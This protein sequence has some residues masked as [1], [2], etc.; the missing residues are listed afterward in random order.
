[1][2][3]KKYTSLKSLREKIYKTIAT[4][5]QGLHELQA[6]IK[7]E[8]SK[9][10]RSKI[11]NKKISDAVEMLK[12]NGKIILKEGK[13]FT[14]ENALKKAVYYWRSKGGYVTIEG[15]DKQYK[16]SGEN[17][18]GYNSP[19]RVNVAVVEENG[20]R[21]AI[22][23]SKLEKSD[24]KEDSIIDNLQATDT[25]LVAGRVVKVSHNDIV[26]I[27]NDRRFTRRIKILNPKPDYIDK[28]CI[29][30]ICDTENHGIPATGI[31]TEVKGD[32]G[33][34]IQEYDAIAESHGA[35]MTWS[36][37]AV[38]TEIDQIPSEVDLKGKKLV[39][40]NG[41]VLQEGDEKIVDLRHLA[42]TTVDPATC[43]DM[44]DAI[45]STYDEK[46]RLV[47][48]TAVANVSKYVDLKSEIGRRYL[49]AGFTIY[50]PN[51]AYNILP[52][53][54]STGICSLNP[55]V[56]RLALV[57]K[58]IV[59]EKT[60]EPISNTIMDAVI[61]SKEKYSYERAQEIYDESDTK[62]EE[63]KKKCVNGEELTKE[64][65]VV[66]NFEASKVLWKN[67]DKRNRIKFET[68]NE[69]DV[70]F[71]EDFSDI[72]NITAQQ[73]IPYHA[74]IEAFML[75]ANEATA[76]FCLEHRI[77]NIYRVHDMPNEDK[78]AMAEEFFSYVDIDFDG[79]LSPLGIKRIIAS[80]EGDE[81]RGKVVNNFLVRMQSKAKYNNSP[82]PKGAELVRTKGKADRARA[83][84]ATM[85]KYQKQIEESLKFME[86]ISHFGLQSKH[87]SHTTSPIRRIADYVTH[88]NILAYIHGREMLDEKTVLEIAQWANQMQDAN[89]Q[90]EREIDDLNSAIYCEHL[91]GDK[92]AVLKGTVCSFKKLRE[93]KD[94]TAQD[95]L[96]LVEEETK[97][98]KVQIPASE[99]LPDARNVTVSMYGSAIINKKNSRPLIKLCDQLT[100]KVKMA[101]RKTREVFA[102]TN[103]SK[104]AEVDV[105]KIFSE[106]NSP[107]VVD[108]VLSEQREKMS[109][110]RQRM[111]NNVKYNSD[112][113]SSIEY[114]EEQQ[115]SRGKK[116]KGAVKTRTGMESDGLEAYGYN[117][118]SSRYFHERKNQAKRKSCE[119]YYD[120]ERDE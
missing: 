92:G 82:N 49:Q 11:S 116:H 19:E 110:K 89:D 58:T 90:A 27:P 17:A 33:N 34:P 86:N 68:K 13:Y 1:M 37:E 29:M 60:G 25:S 45:Y 107:S 99:L 104:E 100:F 39:N 59:D 31:I 79:D 4:T 48:Y 87:Y 41:E 46:G 54:L 18:V 69:Y 118:Q 10:S 50:A 9:G 47:V 35:N 64:E 32:A 74:V 6:R 30:K 114:R 80:V 77:P 106:I 42:F 117:K 72:V 20:D 93:G 3:A 101:D 26:F 66:L 91:I 15:D 57:V 5:P 98:V 71:N 36:D 55:N 24:T 115:A 67:F 51:K 108:P 52:P 81:R 73:H 75:T 38:E 109:V 113:V 53:Q 76:K 88:K 21:K 97:G 23:V 14:T 44:D 84:D 103:L 2:N 94:L 112:Y 62:I 95:I 12:N 119:Q 16:I 105:G 61:N 111:L 22:I 78:L 43:K 56:D 40:E 28:I 96:I 70:E 7:K 83:L 102:T 65:Q 85:E 120:T 8:A 63:L